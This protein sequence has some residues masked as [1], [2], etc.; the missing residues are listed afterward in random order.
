M[1]ET[2]SGSKLGAYRGGRLV[3]WIGGALLAYLLITVVLGIWWSRTPDTFSVG[4]ASA[5]IALGQHVPVGL[6][7]TAVLVEV[8]ETLLDKPGGFISNDMMP[9]GVWLDNMPSWEYGVLI[10]AR[11]MTRALREAFSRSQS[12]SQEDSDLGRAEPRL[13]FSNNSWM[14][15]ASESEYR[16]AIGYLQNYAARLQGEGE[17]ARFYPRADNLSYWL[18]VVSS[19]LGSLSQ[20]LSASVGQKLVAGEQVAADAGVEPEVNAD[21]VALRTPWRQIDNVFFEA[22]GTTWALLHLLRAI[23]VDFA[24][25]LENKSAAVS[26]RQIIRELEET[27]QPIFSPLILNGSGFGPLA[28]HSLV[29]ANYISRANAAIIDLRDLL[30]QG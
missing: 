15:P 8:T 24:P 28:N 23:E 17:R 4:E 3:W 19:R 6:T 16:E 5:E 26:L 25:V 27:Q 7:T 10:Q 2:T 11:D 18:S 13:N 12:Q 22:R 20:R 9:P 29:M 30:S 21:E 1:K 14:L